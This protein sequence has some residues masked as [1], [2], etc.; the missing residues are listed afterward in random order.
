MDYDVPEIL[1]TFLECKMKQICKDL[2]IPYEDEYN[3]YKLK[4][5]ILKT[6]KNKATK[7]TV[8]C[9][10]RVKN[11]GWGRQCSRKCNG[12]TSF[13]TIHNKTIK[14]RQAWEQLGR[15]DEPAPPIFISWYKKKGFEI[16]NSKYFF[17]HNEL[18][19]LSFNEKKQFDLCV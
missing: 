2:D 12:T 3:H 19:K 1:N 10:A 11:N 7:I 4:T 13:C 5:T 16:Q 6:K 18:K 8:K 15:I 14:N 17:A 9:K